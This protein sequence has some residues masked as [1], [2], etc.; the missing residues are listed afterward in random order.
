MGGR[1]GG[2][3]RFHVGA[4]RSPQA[5]F[6]DSMVIDDEVGLDHVQPQRDDKSGAYVLKPVHAEITVI[7]LEEIECA[8]EPERHGE[9]GLEVGA[10]TRGSG[11]D[12]PDFTLCYLFPSRPHYLHLRV[13]LSCAV[14]IV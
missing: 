14:V 11:I 13:R 5:D 7:A 12:E 2:A 4:G 10:G 8:N 3:S 6:A 9:I 1:P